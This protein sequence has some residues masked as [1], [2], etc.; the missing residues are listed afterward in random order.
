LHLGY[1]QDTSYC[2]V[3]LSNGKVIT[4]RDVK[5]WGSSPPN[6]GFNL[7]DPAHVPH[8]DTYEGEETVDLQGDRTPKLEKAQPPVIAI[9]DEQPALPR[10]QEHNDPPG[11]DK[12]VEEEEIP[13][14][15][16]PEQQDNKDS[17]NK[18]E[19]HEAEGRHWMIVPNDRSAVPS[20]EA[21]ETRGR[22]YNLRQD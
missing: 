11:P 9:E 17:N 4:S 6:E 1:Q 16:R 15:L 5:A 7:K 2:R 14:D 19:Y 8:L 12:Q 3:L 13:Q 21:E 22:R 18:S 10:R 20:P